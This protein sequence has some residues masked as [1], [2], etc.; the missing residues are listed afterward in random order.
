MEQESSDDVSITDASDQSAR[1]AEASLPHVCADEPFT[2]STSTT[3]IPLK[4]TSTGGLT[5]LP[6]QSSGRKLYLTWKRVLDVLLSLLALVFL[7]PLM[8]VT[9]ILI[10]WEDGRPVLIAQERAGKDGKPFRMWK[11]RSMVRGAEQMQEELRA[12]S[13]QDGPAFKMRDDPRVTRTGYWMRRSGIDELPQLVNILRGEMSI[14]GP[15]PLLLREQAGCSREES[16]RLSVLP[17]LVCTWQCC[18]GKEE[19]PFSEWMQM[20]LAYVDHFSAWMDVKILL[21]AFRVV[22]RKENI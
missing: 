2:G 11:F 15:R 9:A 14:V 8:A 3:G 5:R 10:F 4:S 19:I 6:G 12:R 1:I 22:L 13:I 17:G 20:D 7:S 21:S 16:R 18:P